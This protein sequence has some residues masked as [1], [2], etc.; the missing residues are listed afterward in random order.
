MNRVNIKQWFTGSKAVKGY[1]CD[2]WPYVQRPRQQVKL[3]TQKINNFF[4][5]SP[6][7]SDYTKI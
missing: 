7:S 6:V 4:V 3:I 2:M 1:I 5:V